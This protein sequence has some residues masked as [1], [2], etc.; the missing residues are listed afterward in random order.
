MSFKNDHDII[1]ILWAIAFIC[2]WVAVG[3][4]HHWI[5]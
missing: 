5:G 1:N 3:I 2:F 4:S